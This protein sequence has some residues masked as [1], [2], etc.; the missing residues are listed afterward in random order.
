[1][2]G[3]QEV[4]H[5]FNLDRRDGRNVVLEQ[6]DTWECR[7][8]AAGRVEMSSWSRWTS[9]NVVMEQLGKSKCRHG[10]AGQVEVSSWSTWKEAKDPRVTKP[11]VR[12]AAT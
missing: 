8:G 9:R 12:A 5:N 3:Q 2:L 7:P 1:M 6:L 4:R 10:E 11:V